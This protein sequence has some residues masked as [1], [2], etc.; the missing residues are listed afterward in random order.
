[1]L[2]MV[3]EV[4]FDLFDKESDMRKSADHNVKIDQLIKLRAF[5]LQA[6]AFEPLSD[7]LQKIITKEG[8]LGAKL[9]E[10]KVIARIKFCVAA[11]NR[12]RVECQVLVEYCDEYKLN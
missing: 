8:S 12:L 9:L 1:M 5:E 4:Y 2:E 3:E 7:F 10:F 6:L 11:C